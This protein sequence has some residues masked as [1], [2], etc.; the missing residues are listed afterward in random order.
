MSA[1]KTDGQSLRDDPFFFKWAYSKEEDAYLF[2]SGMKLSVKE[3]ARSAPTED[4]TISLPPPPD[5][6]I[7][8]IHGGI[9]DL[10]IPQPS[11]PPPDKTIKIHCPKKYQYKYS[12]DY[13]RHLASG[14]L[15]EDARRMA[16]E[17]DYVD[18]DDDDDDDEDDDDEPVAG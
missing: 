9:G 5:P 18:D 17:V 3:P 11:P 15:G 13:I 12:Y 6:A 4:K 14:I 16:L 10:N 8:A 2:R 1:S 7:P